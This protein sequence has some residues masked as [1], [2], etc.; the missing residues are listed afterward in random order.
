MLH[1]DPRLVGCFQSATISSTSVFYLFIDFTKNPIST[2]FSVDVGNFVGDLKDNVLHKN[3]QEVGLSELMQGL[4][5]FLQ[6]FRPNST[7]R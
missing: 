7:R 1:I 6:Q 2:A 5:Y 4:E 3:S